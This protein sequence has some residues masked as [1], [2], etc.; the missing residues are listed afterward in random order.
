MIWKNDLKWLKSTENLTIFWLSHFTPRFSIP[1]CSSHPSSKCP[2]L[3]SS[4]MSA[5]QKMNSQ[6]LLLS[7]YHRMLC[8]TKEQFPA[9]NSR[10]SS[11]EPRMFH[12]HRTRRS[13]CDRG[14]GPSLF[15][16][17]SP[18]SLEFFCLLL[19]NNCFANRQAGSPGF[20][21][22]FAWNR[23]GFSFFDRLLVCCSFPSFVD[24]YSHSTNDWIL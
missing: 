3:D 4:K 19:Q 22:S 16:K 2:Q 13:R 7:F 12:F 15:G 23:I 9:T 21:A 20:K 17:S 8:Q 5:P 10:R 18:F 24:I 6:L 14:R 11:H 1:H